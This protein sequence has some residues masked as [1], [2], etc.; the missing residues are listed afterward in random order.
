[1]Q[2]QVYTLVKVQAVY[3]LAEV[4]AQAY[5]LVEEQAQVYTL[6]EVLAQ[7][8]RLATEEQSLVRIF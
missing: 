4:Q 6:A 5:I 3:R 8:V 2:A 1:M 7:D